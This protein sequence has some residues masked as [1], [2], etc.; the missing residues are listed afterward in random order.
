M[1]QNTAKGKASNVFKDVG[2]FNGFCRGFSPGK[3]SVPGH[4]NSGDGDGVKIFGPKTADY[5]GAGIAD[6]GLG[7]F[8]GG[9]GLGDGNGAVKVVSVGGAQAGDGTAG[10]S[11]GSGELGMGVDDAADLGEFSIEQGMR[12]EVAGGAQGAFDDLAFE[13][14]ND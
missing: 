1:E 4:Q 11:P 7:Y 12:V 2:V 10:L 5:D 13:I 8:S 9:E 14:G 6:V 3:G